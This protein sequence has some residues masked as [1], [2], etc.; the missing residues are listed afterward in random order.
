MKKQEDLEINRIL[1]YI[2]DEMSSQER[3]EFEVLLRD[4]SYLKKYK[5]YIVADH[6]ILLGKN[7]FDNQQAFSQF[8]KQVEKSTSINKTRKNRTATFLK[9]AA[10]FV[11]LLILGTATYIYQN[12]ISNDQVTNQITLQLDDENP[13]ILKDTEI[14]KE[15]KD[16]DGLVLGVQ[17]NSKLLYNTKNKSVAKQPKIHTLHVPNGYLEKHILK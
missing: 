17:E 2:N 5:E 10:I 12:R 11:G 7:D 8:K 15:I 1:K 16:K 14:F 13:K 6:Y 9:Y 4:E 3:S